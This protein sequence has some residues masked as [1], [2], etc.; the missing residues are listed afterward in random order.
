[1]SLA[2]SLVGS[3]LLVAAAFSATTG[4]RAQTDARAK[5]AF[6]FFKAFCVDTNGAKD[7]ALAV[8]GNGNAMA[9][10]LPDEM[11]TRL[12][13]QAGGVA[14]AVRSPSNA[15]LLLGYV[16]MGICEIRIVDADES[17]ILSNFTALTSS[18][19]ASAKGELSQPKTR[20]QDDAHITY[21][22][23]RFDRAGKHAL[24]ALSSS[25]KKIGAQ[26]HLITFGFV[27]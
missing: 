19:Q 24:I 23:Y 11:V 4:A 14:W 1:V 8:I 6:D 21:Q 15:Q 12:Q 26:Q 16:P 10:K 18:L 3:S 2:R 25:D 13:G 22:T 9:N 5:D 27:K 7:R 20:T 17:S